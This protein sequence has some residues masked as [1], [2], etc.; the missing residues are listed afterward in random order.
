MVGAV[1]HEARIFMPLSELVDLEKERARV[2][3]ELKK[4]RGELEGLHAKLNNPGFLNKAPAQVVAAERERAEKLAALAA[5][6]EEQLQS[7]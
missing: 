6:L 3:K 7:M 1:T 4:S 5:K 2:Q